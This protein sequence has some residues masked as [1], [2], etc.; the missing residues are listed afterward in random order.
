MDE[1]AAIFKNFVR[2]EFLTPKAILMAFLSA[3]VLTKWFRRHAPILAS[4]IAAIIIILTFPSLWEWG[5]V[6]AVL[7][8]ISQ[9]VKK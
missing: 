5:I 2:D 6:L 7:F 1:I 9:L 3:L 8:A 4:I